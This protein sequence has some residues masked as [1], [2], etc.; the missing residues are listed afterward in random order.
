M[1]IRINQN[2]IIPP[3][4][5]E[6]VS[7]LTQAGY[8]AYLVGGAVRDF[9]RGEPVKDYDVATNALPDQVEAIF[10]RVLDVGRSFG[11]LKVMNPETR[12]EIEVATF[13][14]ESDYRDHRRPSKV[15]FS[16]LEEDA[17]RRDFT[18]NAL[19]FDLKTNLIWDGFQGLD[20]LKSKSLRAIGVP[21]DRFKEDGLRLVRAVRFSSRFGFKIEDQTRKAILEM[22]PSIRKISLERIRDELERM[23]THSSCRNAIQDLEVLGLLENIL[24]EISVAKLQGRKVWEQTL[25]ALRVL[26]QYRPELPEPKAFY[27][28]QLMIPTFRLLPISAREAEARSFGKRMKL[29]NDEIENM[30]YLILNTPKFREVFSMRDARILRWMR[31]PRFDLL[32]RFHELDAQSFDGNLAGMEFVKSIYAD[33]KRRFDVK[34]L[35]SGEDLMKLGMSPGRQFTEILRSVEDLQLEGQLTSTDEAL[36]YVLKTYV[37]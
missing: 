20:D 16:S 5:R 23:L 25:R 37:R 13:R 18:V 29:S 19:Y 36:M 10:G 1:W 12:R 26:G 24:P 35:V 6:T 30:I 17:K 14:S 27:W 22:S 15:E 21:K 8:E 31:E 7:K 32:L 4:V 28:T 34:P 9:L 33:A 11:V 3:D 2:F